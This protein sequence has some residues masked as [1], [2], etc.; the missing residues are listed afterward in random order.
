MQI[1][2]ANTN[3]SLIVRKFIK[4]YWQTIE[5]NYRPSDSQAITLNNLDYTLNYGYHYFQKDSQITE[6]DNIFLAI[7]DS[8]A[9]GLISFGYEKDELFIYD[10]MIQKNYLGKG[11]GSKL[12]EYAISQATNERLSRVGL[13]V[14]DVNIR[15]KK[16]YQKFNFQFQNFTKLDWYDENEEVILQTTSEYW[17]KNIVE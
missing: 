12:L 5:E 10:L 15:A 11:L 16:L 17:V 9:V 6:L 2:Q 14:D 4:E 3:D 1:T 7:I 13:W 8:Q